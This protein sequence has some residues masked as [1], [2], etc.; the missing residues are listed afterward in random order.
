ME[1]T[2]F[3]YFSIEKET[4]INI[5]KYSCALFC[6]NTI[7][8]GCEYAQYNARLHCYFDSS[9]WKHDEYSQNKKIKFDYEI[10]YKQKKL[11]IKY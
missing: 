1:D 6:G 10:N 5:P 8:S 2:I 11:N 9:N 7:H 3:N 4:E